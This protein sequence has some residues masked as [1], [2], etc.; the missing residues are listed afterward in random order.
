MEPPF[1]ALFRFLYG[2]VIYHYVALGEP[3]VKGVVAATESQTLV[4]GMCLYLRFTN[5]V[6]TH[7]HFPSVLLS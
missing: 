1:L 6:I 5:S 3:W 4:K 2:S 7:S